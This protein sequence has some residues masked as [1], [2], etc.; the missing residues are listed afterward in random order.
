MEEIKIIR[1]YHV[2]NIETKKEQYI[3]AASVKELLN[4]ISNGKLDEAKARQE[5]YQE[6]DK[7]FWFGVWVAENDLQTHGFTEY[8]GCEIEIDYEYPEGSE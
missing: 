3:K 6:Y 7:D 2:T 1:N 4:I 5:Q 8:A